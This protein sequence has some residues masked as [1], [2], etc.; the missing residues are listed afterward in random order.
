MPKFRKKP[1]VIDAIQWT[2]NLLEL[3]EFLKT[4]QTTAEPYVVSSS[5]MIPTLEGLMEARVG[6]YIIVGVNKELYPC[7][8]DIFAKTYDMESDY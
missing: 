2:G 5:L 4:T 1:V 7:K 8:S 6:D 3:K